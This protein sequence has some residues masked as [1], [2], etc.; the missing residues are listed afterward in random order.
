MKIR[1]PYLEEADSATIPQ[2]GGVRYTVANKYNRYVLTEL[3]GQRWI[4]I[5]KSITDDDYIRLSWFDGSSTKE[6]EY[7]LDDLKQYGTYMMLFDLE[8]R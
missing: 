1:I 6:V 2:V 3:L 8:I 7:S 4:T 5:V